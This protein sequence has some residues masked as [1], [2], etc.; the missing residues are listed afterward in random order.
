MTKEH[1]KLIIGAS[2]RSTTRYPRIYKIPTEFLS[3]KDED[4]DEEFDYYLMDVAGLEDSAGAEVEIANR[5]T[6]L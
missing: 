3:D 5:I 6:N 1:K 2:N 4:E